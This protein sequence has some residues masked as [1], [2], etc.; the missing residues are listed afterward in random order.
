MEVKYKIKR[1]LE[2][3]FTHYLGKTEPLYWWLRNKVSVNA[4]EEVKIK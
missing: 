4:L 3:Y 2:T 1:G